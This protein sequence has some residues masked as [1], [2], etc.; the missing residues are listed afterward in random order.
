MVIVVTTITDSDQKS[1]KYSKVDVP[2]ILEKLKHMFLLYH[3]HIYIVTR[4]KSS[5]T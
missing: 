5:T 3:I 2:E 4:F 1:K